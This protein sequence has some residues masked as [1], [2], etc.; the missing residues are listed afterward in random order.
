[1]G[2]VGRVGV[3]VSFWVKKWKTSMSSLLVN[4]PCWEEQPSVRNM[5]MHFFPAGD[6]S[7]GDLQPS[8]GAAS[9]MQAGL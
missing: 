3:D 9:A 8:P 1:M 6:T 4:L 5:C 7:A 2:L